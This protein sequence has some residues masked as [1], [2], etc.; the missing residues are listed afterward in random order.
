MIQEER[1]PGE[2]GV[3]GQA[4]EEVADE[5][6]YEGVDKLQELGVNATD[7][8]RLKEAGLYT[9]S[10]IMMTTTKNLGEIK[11]NSSLACATLRG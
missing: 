7:I 11:G 1:Q 6:H 10:S 5:Q 2:E 9:I 3:E 8:Q 4:E